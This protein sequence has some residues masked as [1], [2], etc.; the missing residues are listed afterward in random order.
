M[1]KSRYCARILTE[2]S[3]GYFP[4]LVSFFTDDASRLAEL[5]RS[6]MP[7]RRRDRRCIIQ[8]IN[9]HSGK[10]FEK[11]LPKVRSLPPSTLH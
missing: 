7:F 2:K 4:P 9:L 5:W 11:R 6:L 1:H 3:S 8:L 10:S